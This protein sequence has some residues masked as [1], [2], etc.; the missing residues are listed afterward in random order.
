M[1]INDLTRE[2]QKLRKSGQI[3][4]PNGDVYHI[5]NK[6]KA[7]HLIF[8]KLQR[9]T[10]KFLLDKGLLFTVEAGKT[11]YN[12]QAKKIKNNVYLVVY[13]EL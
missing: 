12:E 11:V 8:R 10:F 13:G 4:K 2:Y 6:I 5:L 1:H 9:N 3:D 7:N